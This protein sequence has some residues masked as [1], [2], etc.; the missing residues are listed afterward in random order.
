M[1]L[2]SNRVEDLAVFLEGFR[3]ARDMFKIA[4]SDTPAFHHFHYWLARHFGHTQTSR[5]WAQILR[6]QFV[7]DTS[8][9]DAFCQLI[10][11]FRKERLTLV[12]R[13]RVDTTRYNAT[14]ISSGS[15]LA[16]PA[17]VSLHGYTGKDAFFLVLEWVD[18]S[19]YEDFVGS[20]EDA[21][22]AASTR[23]GISDADWHVV[24]RTSG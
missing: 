8:A 2:G 13:A 7:D 5:G 19:R 20:Q 21:R 4:I 12:A 1:Y 17:S 16:V 18:G 11:E 6:D 10:D 3:T 24:N 9:F 22:L 15:V 23:Y 14:V